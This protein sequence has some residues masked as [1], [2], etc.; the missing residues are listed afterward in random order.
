[1]NSF[2]CQLANGRY[3]ARLYFAETF[4]GITV[5]AS[6]CSP[7]ASRTC[8]RGFRYLAKTASQSRI[9]SKRCPWRLPR[10]IPDCLHEPD[11]KPEINAIEITPQASPAAGAG[12]APSATS[13]GAA[14]PDEQER[15][16]VS[17][18]S[19]GGRGS[20]GSQITLG[21][22][23][24][25]AFDDPPAEFNVVRDDIPHGKLEVI[26]YDSKTVALAVT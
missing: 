16:A 25:P 17:R 6:A 4:E 7:S 20:F 22:D 9:C 3:L 12:A 18:S 13:A 11:R 21:P 1:M 5:P 14:A 8:I 19:R 15:P 26:Q 2:S 23:D 24:K 10:R